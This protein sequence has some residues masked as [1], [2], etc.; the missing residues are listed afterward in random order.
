MKKVTL[1]FNSLSDIAI[2]TKKLKTG[3]LLNTFNT[4]ITATLSEI[5]IEQATIL[6]NARVIETTKMYSLINNLSMAK[7]K[8][9]L[10][11]LPFYFHKPYRT[12]SKEFI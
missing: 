5:D 12:K 11:N 4:T 7:Q 8:G 3:Y 1:Q 2:F 9:R 10:L 6:F